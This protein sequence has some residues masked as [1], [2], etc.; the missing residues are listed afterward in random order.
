VIEVGSKLRK[1]VNS[2]EGGERV[3]VAGA[4][5]ARRFKLSTQ[6]PTLT[7]FH[8]TGYTRVVEAG[9]RSISFK[10]VSPKK[11]VPGQ[12]GRAISALGYLGKQNATVET[13]GQIRG[14]LSE[15]EYKNLLKYTMH[16]SAWMSDLLLKFER[17]G[18][19]RV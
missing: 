8:T 10:H 13:I 1:S 15:K 9:N 11:I 18:K 7:I 16:M 2:S 4:E 12:A 5:A 17:E 19:N 6:V 14:Q 3:V